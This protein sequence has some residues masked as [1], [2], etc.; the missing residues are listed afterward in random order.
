MENT[1][2]ALNSLSVH[3][4]NSLLTYPTDKIQHLNVN[5]SHHT[6]HLQWLNGNLTQ[7]S[8]DWATE[9]FNILHFFLDNFPNKVLSQCADSGFWM[10]KH[11]RWGIFLSVIILLNCVQACKIT[12]C[13]YFPLLKNKISV[14]NVTFS[15]SYQ[16]GINGSGIHGSL[17]LILL[18]FSNTSYFAS[19]IDYLLL[20]IFTLFWYS[21]KLY[22][23]YMLKYSEN[24][25]STTDVSFLTPRQ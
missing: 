6:R 25:M 24:R 18:C 17:S 21:D 19:H 22:W 1:A 2:R 3:F 14:I 23:G 12:V 4:G 10:S 20:I 8:S 11:I 16:S 5:Y 7:C 13:M 9:H 15:S